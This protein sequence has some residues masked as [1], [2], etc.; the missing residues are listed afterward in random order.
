MKAL[1]FGAAIVVT[2]S[3]VGT[4]L[5]AENSHAQVSVP[6]YYRKDGTYVQP[7]QRT[8]P[9]SNL[10]NNYSTPGN[11]NPNTGRTTPGGN[12]NTGLYGT[13]YR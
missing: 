5:L 10:D 3:G 1:F 7:H 12:G 4:V 8:R 11:Y 6:G 2:A 9:D 13:L